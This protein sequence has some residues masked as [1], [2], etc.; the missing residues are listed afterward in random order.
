MRKLD[1]VKFLVGLYLASAGVLLSSPALADDKETLVQDV[2]AFMQRCDDKSKETL[3]QSCANERTALH[4][5]QDA[6]HLSNED[7]NRLLGRTRAGLH[8][9]GRGPWW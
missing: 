9:G 8:G 2:K 1:A 5:R 4:R 7:V 3:S 6:L